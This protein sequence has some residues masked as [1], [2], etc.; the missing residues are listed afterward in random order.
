MPYD[1]K[2]MLNV[3]ESLLARCDAL[4]DFV[5]RK[6]LRGKAHRSDVMRTALALGLSELEKVKQKEAEE[7]GV[8]V[9]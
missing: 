9:I 7:G 8:P 6:S 4:Q 1:E 3:A 2:V 5:A